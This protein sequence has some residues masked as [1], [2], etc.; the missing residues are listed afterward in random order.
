MRLMFLGQ[1]GFI[2]EGEEKRFLIDP[3]LSNYVVESGIGD[4]QFFSREFPSPIQP[5]ELFNIDCIF[6]TH[7]H[8]DH[9]DPLTIYPILKNNP[10]CQ[11]IGPFP[12]INALRKGIIPENQFH[13]PKTGIWEQEQGM[14][15]LALPSAHYELNQNS[16]SGEFP[17]YG[18]VIQVD[19]IVIYHSGD[20]IMHETLLRDL[21][22]A[23]SNYNLVCLPVNGRDKERE[24]LGITG[25]LDPEE[26]LGLASAMH[27][28]YLFPMHNDLFR[29]N[30]L[31]PAILNDY[32]EQKYPFLNVKWLHPGEI[33]W[34]E[35]K[36][37]GH[38]GR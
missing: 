22:K 8:A 30:R 20:T 23:E 34:Y 28:E 26:A 38:L 37:K 7:D 36:K 15:Y 2:F 5:E 32:R 6:I 13:S 14:R 17:Y 11:L 31:D 27:A 35:T 18:Y 10:H 33:F 1:A 16:K 24:A 4:A 21:L 9:C 3:Y 25:N 19:G 29:I 12:V